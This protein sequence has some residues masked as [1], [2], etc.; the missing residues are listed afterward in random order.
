MSWRTG[1]GRFRRVGG[2]PPPEGEPAEP[3]LE[4]AYLLMLGA[5]ATAPPAGAAEVVA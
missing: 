3:T 4:D 2:T 1:T 5:G